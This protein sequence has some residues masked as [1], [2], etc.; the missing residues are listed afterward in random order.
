MQDDPSGLVTTSLIDSIYQ[1]IYNTDSLSPELKLEAMA[2]LFHHNKDFI[3][4]NS[5]KLRETM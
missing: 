2:A 4:R 3:E 1:R 5:D